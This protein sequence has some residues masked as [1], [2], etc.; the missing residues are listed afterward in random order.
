MSSWQ[1][2]NRPR[3]LA[4]LSDGAREHEVLHRHRPHYLCLLD[5]SIG[6]QA[7]LMWFSNFHS[8]IIIELENWIGRPSLKIVMQ[9][10]NFL[11]TYCFTTLTIFFSVGGAAQ[12]CLALLCREQNELEFSARFWQGDRDR[13][14]KVCDVIG[15]S[16]EYSC[17]ALALA[18]SLQLV[19]NY[20]E[21]PCY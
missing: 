7:V 17:S 1:N 20:I 3:T 5:S 13:Y 2:G 18:G 15:G 10:M 11:I 8:G 14:R 21:L 6:P 12:W 4:S 16:F 9:K 19:S